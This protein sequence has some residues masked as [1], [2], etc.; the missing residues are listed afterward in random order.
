VHGAQ[1]TYKI[2]ETFLYTSGTVNILG[3]SIHKVKEIAEGLV[4]VTKETGL[5]VN[6]DKTKYM[7]MSVEQ[8]AGLSQNLKVNN[9]SIERVEEFKY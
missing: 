5:E 2:T 4:V 8:S 3:G 7:F 6:T 9:N 1:E